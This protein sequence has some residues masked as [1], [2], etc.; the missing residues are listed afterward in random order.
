MKDTRFSVISKNLAGGEG[1]IRNHVQ[2]EV[3]DAAWF[4]TNN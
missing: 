1:G 2:A 3:I 4:V